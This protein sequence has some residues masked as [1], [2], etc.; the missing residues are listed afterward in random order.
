GPRDLENNQ[1][2]AVRRDTSEKVQIQLDGD[3][4]NNINNELN[5]IDNKMKLGSK[6]SLVNRI[7]SVDSIEAIEETINAGNVASFAWCGE[8]ECG[9][10]IEEKVNFDILGSFQADKVDY[11]IK[12]KGNLCPNCG[13]E[14]K[15]ISTIAKTY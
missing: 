4:V 13:K 12:I 6:T 14:G 1:A 5:D 15:I 9:K 10:D 8:E 7:V 3:F 11:E 2:V